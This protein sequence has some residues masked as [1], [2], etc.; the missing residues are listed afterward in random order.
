MLVATDYE[1]LDIHIFH[2]IAYIRRNH[3][4][5]PNACVVDG[6][7]GAT[8]APNTLL[9]GWVKF[10]PNAG[11]AACWLNALSMYNKETIQN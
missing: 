11:F 5:H 2:N 9:V 3:Y 10:A 6:K 1:I 7:V 4:L 8:D